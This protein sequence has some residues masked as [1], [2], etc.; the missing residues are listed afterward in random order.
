MIPLLPHCKGFSTLSNF[1]RLLGLQLTKKHLRDLD[2]HHYQVTN[3]TDTCPC[4]CLHPGRGSAVL[5]S[6]LTASS[7][8]LRQK[9]LFASLGLQA[10]VSPLSAQCK[11]HQLTWTC[12]VRPFILVLSTSLNEQG[13]SKCRGTSDRE[14]SLK[15]NIQVLCLLPR[16][17][18][19]HA[20]SFGLAV[21]VPLVEQVGPS[22]NT[23]SL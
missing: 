4:A 17:N 5:Q 9:L 13:D 20:Q 15:K 16:R 3:N 14:K 2:L 18:N 6:A 22:K 7:N 10:A 19:I 11:V 23:V 1:S 21:S 8:G 12:P